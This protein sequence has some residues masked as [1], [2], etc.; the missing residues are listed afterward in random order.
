MELPKTPTK[1]PELHEAGSETG[2][3][4]NGES[5]TESGQALPVSSTEFDQQQHSPPNEEP[6]FVSEEDIPQD[7]PDIEGQKM[8][9]ELPPE[10]GQPSRPGH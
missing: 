4:N 2:G 9:E 8:I 1:T 10:S 3:Q 6:S 5:N 7:G